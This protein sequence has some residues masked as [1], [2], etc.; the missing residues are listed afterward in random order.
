[1]D[2]LPF[3]RLE[4]TPRLHEYIV[5]ATVLLWKWLPLS[6][7]RARNAEVYDRT[8]NWN[9][10][11]LPNRRK[12]SWSLKWTSLGVMV[13]N[14]PVDSWQSLRITGLIENWVFHWKLHISVSN[15]PLVTPHLEYFTNKGFSRNSNDG[16]EQT[17]TCTGTS[18]MGLAWA[19]DKMALRLPIKA[20]VALMDT[21]RALEPPLH[22]TLN[23]G[24]QVDTKMMTMQ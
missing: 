7:R 10:K 23:C 9:G 19:G 15:T 14:R 8:E 18:V 6:H 3:L 21:M 20:S 1:M 12:Y 4:T 22:P 24:C 16:N 13:N 17:L 5:A 11:T 2:S